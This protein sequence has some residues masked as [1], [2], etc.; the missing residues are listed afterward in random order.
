MTV[1]CFS[2]SKLVHFSTLAIIIIID[3]FCTN[4]LEDQAQWRDKTKGLSKLVIAKQLVNE[5]KF[6]EKCIHEQAQTHSSVYQTLRANGK[7]FVILISQ[8]E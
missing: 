4:I 5:F 7:Y 2:I 8:G 6:L 3:F 1:Y